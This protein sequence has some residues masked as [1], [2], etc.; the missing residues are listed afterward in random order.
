MKKIQAWVL[1]V[2]FMWLSAGSAL[3]APPE[4]VDPPGQ[5]ALVVGVVVDPP[6]CMKDAGGRW[7]GLTVDLWTL[8]A[9]E[10][11]RPFVFK[12][13]SFEA[14]LAS[15]TEGSIDLSVEPLFLTSEREGKYEL[16]TPLGTSRMAVATLYQA[17]D[18]PWWEA[19]KIFFAWGTLKV[20]LL[21][22]LAL[23]VIGLIFWLLERKSNPEHFGENVHKGIGAGM[24][25][26]GS[27]LTSGVCFGISLKTLTG[28]ILGLVW[29]LLCALALSAVIAS[30]TS[31]LTASRSSEPE[32]NANDLRQM[33]LG[34]ERSTLPAFIIAKIGGRNST[35]QSEEDIL[36]ALMDRKIDGYL[37]DEITLHAYAQGDYRDKISVYPTDLRRR[38]LAMAM[39]KDSPLR[40]PLNVAL[41]KI[42]DTPAWDAILDRYGLEKN[43]EAKGNRKERSHSADAQ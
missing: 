35:F 3:A 25:W 36:R 40:R 28:R 32:L 27:T 41:L 7:T 21:L 16:S 22:F 9:R 37:A 6:Y 33:H 39:P 38:A 1:L 19:L 34:A 31:S 17:K 12:E 20:I 42:M 13:L 2:G 23:I 4:T 15:L 24:Y 18:H 14:L 5:K 26:A 8:A 30:L 10:M 43:L 29:M 11:N